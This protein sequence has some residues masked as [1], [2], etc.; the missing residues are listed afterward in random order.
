MAY[1]RTNYYKRARYII[2]VYN[3]AKF[4]DVPDTWIVAN[5]F[6]KHN[7]NIGYRQWLNIKGLR[8]PKEAPKV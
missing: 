6:P 4:S 8:I 7:I 3:T 1:N 5:V 2:E